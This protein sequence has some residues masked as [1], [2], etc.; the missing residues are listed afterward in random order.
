[1]VMKYYPPSVVPMT[2]GPRTGRYI[3]RT[4]RRLRRNIRA[5]N[6]KEC[7]NLI[8]AHMLSR[9]RVPRSNFQLTSIRC[10]KS[11]SQRRTSV[12]TLTD[13]LF[14]CCKPTERNPKNMNSPIHHRP[15]RCRVHSTS[16][17]LSPRICHHQL[18]GSRLMVSV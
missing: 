8:P 9:K 1:M 3:A 15:S 14:V 11:N 16:R 2:S 7:N 6:P 4:R 5:K 10:A 18:E 12:F 13:A 17:H